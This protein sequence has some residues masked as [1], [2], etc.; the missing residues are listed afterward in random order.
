MTGSKLDSMLRYAITD[1]ARFPGNEESRQA[2]LLA[3]AAH[4]ADAGVEFIQLREKDLSAG[5]L[6]DLARR[7]MEVLHAQNANSAHRSAPKLLINSRADVAVAAQADG[8][9]L[10]SSLDALTPAQIRALYASAGLPE[11]VVSVSC[12][13]LADVARARANAASCILFG[14][15]FEKVVAE[16]RAT[17]GFVGDKKISDGSGLDLL[18]AAVRAAAPIPVFA[19]GG[20]SHENAPACLA[21]G[22]AGI[23]A[24]RLFL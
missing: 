15:V 13:S 22:A 5:E 10:T 1:R 24:I 9:H 18:A 12:H 23:A 4:L 19:L 7:L 8:V 16:E 11:P 3:Q 21:A 6:A 14:P 2:A 17:E 20:I